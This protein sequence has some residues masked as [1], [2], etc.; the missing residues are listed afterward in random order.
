LKLAA[1]VFLAV[2]QAPGVAD[3]AKNCGERDNEQ[4]DNTQ[5]ENDCEQ[6]EKE[7][8][9]ENLLIFTNENKQMSYTTS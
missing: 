6:Q 1:P 9:A 3:F 8:H 4:S 5:A 7:C 2:L